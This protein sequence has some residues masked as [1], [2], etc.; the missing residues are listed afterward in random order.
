MGSVPTRV[1]LRI[2]F[3]PACAA[4]RNGLFLS[5]AFGAVWLVFGFEIDEEE[6]VVDGAVGELTQALM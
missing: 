4:W 2:V 5:G 3:D 1:V 6:R